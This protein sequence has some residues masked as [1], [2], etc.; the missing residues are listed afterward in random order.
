[1]GKEVDRGGC[2]C[3]CNHGGVG[4]RGQ[5]CWYGESEGLHGVESLVGEES[6]IY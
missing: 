4:K 2:F 1:M 6:M 3:S 5:Q